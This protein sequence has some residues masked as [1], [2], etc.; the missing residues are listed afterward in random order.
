MRRALAALALALFLPWPA[1]AGSYTVKPGETLSELAERYG[2]TVERLLKLNGLKDANSLQAGSKLVVP[3][4]GGTS[5]ARPGRGGGG[6]YTVKP[7]DTLSELAERFGISVER[8]KQLN[9][10]Q[11]ANDLQAGSQLVVPGAAGAGRSNRAKAAP[12]GS[13]TY[14]VQPG[15]TL[16]ALA[17]RY[18]VS[19]D[20]LI[21]L[22]NLKSAN[23]LQAGSQLVVPGA[24]KTAAAKARSKPVAVAK[25]AKEHEV[26]PGE[27]LSHIAEAYGVS[28]DR[29][30]ALNNI[31]EPN[32][33]PAG[34][35]LKLPGG[36][37]AASK[38][39]T[40]PAPVAAKPSPAE[41]QPTP[42]PTPAVATTKPATTVKPAPAPAPGPGPPPRRRSRQPVRKL[43]SRRPR[44]G[45]SPASNRR[46]PPQ[47]PPPADPPPADRSSPAGPIPRRPAQPPNPAPWPRPALP[48]G[49]PTAPCRWTGPTG[50]PWAAA[51][52][53]PASTA[54]GN[55]ST[56]RSTAP[57]AS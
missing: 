44:P 15:D 48:T 23:D 12:G 43:P 19:V 46:P 31:K 13:G 21:Q 11:S 27:T 16:S 54:T 9:G 57:P 45:P 47:W 40:R 4:G 7:G 33:I 22:N 36:S 41:K 8:L 29:L 37:A 17:D 51:T 39:A 3:G 5:L 20:R 1:L 30:I 32:S 18:G 50:S 35:R 56:W 6:G 14:T 28:I 24:A 26:Q 42:K 52:W 38:A 49:A 55:L 2:V 10:L 53:P 34:S 25:G